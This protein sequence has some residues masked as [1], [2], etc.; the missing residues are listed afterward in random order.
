MFTL[1]KFECFLGFLILFI[2]LFLLTMSFGDGVIYDKNESLCRTNDSGKSYCRYK[3]TISQFYVNSDGLVLL[4]IGSDFDIANAKEK[5]Y[6][7]KE[8]N[9]V[10]LAKDANQDDSMREYLYSAFLN[11][12]EVE[13]HMWSAENGRLVVDRFWIKK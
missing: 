9:T 2:T 12:K 8:T 7:I 5:G 4:I 3:G 11:K 10:S 6:V 13:L 1:N